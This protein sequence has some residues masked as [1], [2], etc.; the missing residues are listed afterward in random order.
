MTLLFSAE[1]FTFQFAIQKCKDWDIQN[2]NFACCFVW[3]WNMAAHF[4]RETQKDTASETTVPTVVVTKVGCKNFVT[5]SVVSN[6]QKHHSTLF[7][8]V[9]QSKHTY[10]LVG[11]TL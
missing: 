8:R 4:E 10:V 3:V 7:L 11:M 9:M 6:T 2:Y 1:L 5:G